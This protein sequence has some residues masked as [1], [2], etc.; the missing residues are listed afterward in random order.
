M[1][2]ALIPELVQPGNLFA[3]SVTNR[4][5]ISGTW[6]NTDP[7]MLVSNSSGRFR[8]YQPAISGVHYPANPTDPYSILYLG[9]PGYEGSPYTYDFRPGSTLMQ[10]A[11]A[12]ATTASTAMPTFDSSMLRWGIAV[13]RRN[14]GGTAFSPNYQGI[15]SMVG[16]TSVCYAHFNMGTS[17]PLSRAFRYD[18]TGLAVQTLHDF[19][20]NTW[21]PV[22][23]THGSVT[24]FS[25][26]SN[27]YFS[28]G[29]FPLSANWGS[30]L[31]LY[32]FPLGK[33]ALFMGYYVDDAELLDLLDSMNNGPPSP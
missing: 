33:I 24:A 31:G 17:S 3:P 22:A 20:L 26:I 18:G 27:P 19:A 10:V 4:F 13:P 9:G 21:A 15:Y 2:S 11:T 8:A 5:S 25:S 6:T 16:A 32:D 7:K 30:Q 29:A 23:S 12:S 28:L 1:A 14:S